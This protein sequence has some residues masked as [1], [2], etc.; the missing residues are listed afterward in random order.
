MAYA[1]GLVNDSM[2][3]VAATISASTS[4]APATG[5]R[6]DARGRFFVLSAAGV[7]VEHSTSQLQICSP[8]CLSNSMSH[9]SFKMH[10]P[11]WRSVVP[12]AKH[13]ICT[14]SSFGDAPTLHAAIVKAHTSQMVRASTNTGGAEDIP[15]GQIENKCP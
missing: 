15:Q 7:S 5:T 10:A 4:Q 6:P 9:M 11:A 3:P 1:T 8:T 14:A 12:I 2:P 13:V